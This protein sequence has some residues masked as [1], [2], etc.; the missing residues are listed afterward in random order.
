MAADAS[1]LI[2][3]SD[4]FLGQAL[5]DQLRTNGFPHA[6]CVA[7]GLAVPGA[8]C[9][10]QPDV[11]L[12]NHYFD[13]PDDLLSCC[14]AK[15]AAPGSVIVALASVGPAARFVRQ[16]NE[17]NACLHSVLEKP[18][19][20]G[21]L[22]A[23]LR[24]LVSRVRA[25]KA[26]ESRTTKLANLLP[27][28]AMTALEIDAAGQG[29]LLE[30][31]MLFTDIRRSS[32]MATRFAPREFFDLLNRTLSEQSAKVREFDG[33]VVKYTGDGLMALFRGMGRSYLALR[34]GIALAEMGNHTALPFGVGVA[35]GL[36]LAGFVGDAQ[37]EG[38]LRQYDVLGATVHLS[39]RLCSLAEAGQ[40][41]TTQQ[42]LST[43]RMRARF[44]ALGPL[45]VRGF[46]TPIDCVSMQPAGQL[47]AG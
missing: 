5:A 40:V 10:L 7:S 6:T 31:A 47:Q 22:A 28:G 46:A 23:V 19:S 26:L 38:H 44:R 27:Q 43:S 20:D 24:G 42:L 33:A 16:W 15:L 30:A 45:Q 37:S 32:E 35:E 8:A 36:V 41:V 11:V 18:L 2:I 3:D 9:R 13:R 4:A 17:E 29:E 25:A 12:F 14:S 21:Q 1:V 34:C 39:A